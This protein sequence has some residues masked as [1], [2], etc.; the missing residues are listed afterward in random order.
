MPNRR[1][2]IKHILALGLG[3]TALLSHVGLLLQTASA[4]AK[5]RIVKRGTPLSK[6]M[7]ANPARLDTSR[8]ETT[9]IEQFD[10]MGETNRQV[11]I[12][13]WRLV[14]EGAVRHPLEF[15]YDE[16]RKRPIIERNVLLVCPG[17]FA[18]NGYWRGFSVATLLHEAG[19]DPTATH[20]KFT[21]SGGFRKKSKRFKI[22]EV[23]ANKIFI[24]H[25][26]NDQDIPQR[27]GYPMRLVAEDHRGHR[28]IKY[29]NRI[30]V[31][32]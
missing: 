20:V 3:A 27:H 22:G 18:Y 11:D 23:L 15:S 31:I 30:E 19:Y 25:G 13:R 32:A 9:A 28:W 7:H 2:T 12:K 17:F 5:R 29:I 4:K 1:Q 8:L 26:V 10:V 21:G 14:V 24:A 16:L 6:L